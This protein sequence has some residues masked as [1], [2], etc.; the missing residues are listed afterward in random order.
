MPLGAEGEFALV[1]E[2]LQSALDRAGQPVKRGSMAHEHD[3]LNLLVESSVRLANTAGLQEYLP[4]LE[5]LAGRD[6]H[7][8][9][10]PV[11]RR[12]RGALHR[13]AGRREQ[14]RADLNA[15]LE[16]F[17]GQG[18][19]WQAGR[20]LLELGELERA[21]GE[22]NGARGYYT[23]ALAEFRALGAKPDMTRSQALLAALEQQPPPLDWQE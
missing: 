2:Q 18:M 10:V 17:A 15:A 3:V 20:T 11:A 6:A 7:K 12:A 13:M 1:Q 14:A 21:S 8:L 9:Y 19:R 22:E 4:R 16:Q 5:Q 23:Q